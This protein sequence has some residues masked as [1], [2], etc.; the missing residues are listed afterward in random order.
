[1]CQTIQLKFAPDIRFYLSQLKEKRKVLIDDI[2]DNAERIAMDNVIDQFKEGK[3]GSRI[4]KKEYYKV[5]HC[6]KNIFKAIEDIKKKSHELVNQQ[7]V[8]R[9]E[10]TKVN[11]PAARGKGTKDRAQK[12]WDSLE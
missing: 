9:V 12:F 4:S 3:I 5:L 8:D 6:L 1:M 7:V 10:K 2:E 11:R